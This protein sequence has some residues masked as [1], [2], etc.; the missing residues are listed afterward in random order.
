M[1]DK[2]TTTRKPRITRDE[3]LV[4]EILE[5]I[6]SG[7]SVNAICSEPG[8]PARKSFYMWIIEDDKLRERYESALNARVH[9]MSEDLLDIADAA[10]PTTP[11]GTTDTGAV[12][13]Q[14]LQVDTRKWL[15]SKLVPKKYGDRVDHTSSDG[16]MS[17]PQAIEIVHVKPAGK[18]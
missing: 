6:M 9:S 10:V 17:P 2:V 15:L 4:D 8:M 11:M 5:R 1:T 3:S 13:K 14:R 7:E 18:D 12:A 16:S